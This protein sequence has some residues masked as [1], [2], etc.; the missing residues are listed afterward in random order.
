MFDKIE[1]NA[2]YKLTNLLQAFK[3][4]SFYGLRN[5]HKF[6]IPQ[7]KTRYGNTEE[8]EAIAFRKSAIDDIDNDVSRSVCI[9]MLL[10]SYA[11]IFH[12]SYLDIQ[13]Q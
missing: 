8:T 1:N 10:D 3:H 9:F 13:Q 6:D 4:H 2:N 12:I 5:R 7:F 11:L